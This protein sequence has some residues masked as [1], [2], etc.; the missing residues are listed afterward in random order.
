MVKESFAAIGNS[1]RDL[2]KSP[3]TLGLLA[4]L[5]FLL[6][7]AAY[8]FIST[9]VGNIFQLILT[10]F[11]VVL[12]PLLFF[13]VQTSATAFGNGESSSLKVFSAG[14][15]S[16]WKIMLVSIP[17]IGLVVLTCYLLAKLQ[18]H[19]GSPAAS[20]TR[21]V[22]SHDPSHIATTT[23]LRWFDVLLA[24]IR[25]IVLGI[26]LPLVAIHYWLAITRIGLW[27][28]VKG[29]LRVV[30]QALSGRSVLIYSIGMVFFGLIP[31]FLVFTRTPVK[32]GW[33]ELIVFGLRITLTFLF[34]LCGWLITVRALGSRPFEGEVAAPVVETPIHAEPAHAA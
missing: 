31:Y 25:L 1:A 21:Y 4:V 23:P 27:A 29:T 13:I 5:Y 33:L 16:F 7:A 10:G 12:V 6:L 8:L 24:S 30:G 14:L 28:S 18:T 32:N 15:K 9:G 3:G 2:L 20:P 26:V 11:T 17:L 19:F 34:T 22:M